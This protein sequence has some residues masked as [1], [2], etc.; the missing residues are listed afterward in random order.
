MINI[1]LS[2]EEKKTL[3]SGDGWS[4]TRTQARLARAFGP[5]HGFVGGT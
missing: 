5:G 3:T 4:F 2:E 1:E